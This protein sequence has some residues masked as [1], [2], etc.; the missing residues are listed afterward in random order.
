MTLALTAAN[1]G[2]SVSGRR[3]KLVTTTSP[4]YLDRYGRACSARFF[5][6]LVLNLVLTHV[7]L[8]YDI[9]FENG[10]EA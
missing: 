4:G 6:A 5:A 3:F 8:R 10:R 1:L 2:G 9:K 7:V